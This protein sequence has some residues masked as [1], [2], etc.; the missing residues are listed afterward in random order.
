MGRFEDKQLVKLKSITYRGG[1]CTI[2]R[3]DDAWVIMHRGRYVGECDTYCEAEVM[4]HRETGRLS[5][6][7]GD[8][9]AQAAMKRAEINSEAAAEARAW[10]LCVKGTDE[11]GKVDIEDG[12]EETR[13]D[14]YIQDGDP[15][16]G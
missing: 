5:S 14:Y 13:G 2:L 8:A 7:D 4:S 3:G 6:L 16:C 11:Y 10:G 1:R 15:R 9:V 12:T